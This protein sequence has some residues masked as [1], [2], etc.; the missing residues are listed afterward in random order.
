LCSN[1]G[2]TLH[3]QFVQVGSGS[4]TTL[5]PGVD[6]A[7]RNSYPSG[8]PNVIKN[9]AGKPIPTNDWWSAKLNKNHVSNLFTYPFTLKTVTSGLVVSYIP[10]GVIDDLEP[11]T[12]GVTGLNANKANVSDYSD[13]TVTL[14]WQN[15]SHE[16][17][18]TAGI[19]MP[20]LYFT[21]AAGD[22]AQVVV[23]SGSV[24]LHN[25][26]LVIQNAKNGASFAVYAPVG[27]TWTNNAGTY[28]SNL[29][30][31][32][33]WSM[34]FI[35]LTATNVTNVA[36]EYKKY[37]YVFPANT[38]VQWNYDESSSVVRTDFLVS[39]EVKEGSNDKMLIGLLPHQW[40]NLSSDS[41][42]PD[43]YS[44]ESVRG[45]IKTMEG[46]SFSVENT[47]KGILPTLPYLSNYSEGFNPAFLME[48][49][50]SIESESLS[51]W[52]DSYNEGQSMNRLIQVA[53]IADLMGNTVAL[54]KIK[55][56]IK[57]RLEDWLKAEAGEVAFLFYYNSTWTALI[58]YPAGHGQ[59]NNLNDHHFHWGYFIH[60]AAF[61]EQYEP[62]W[63]SQWGEMVN[64]LVRD[65]ASS[66]RADNMY[67]FLRNFS[68]YAGHCWAN[69]FATF[70][71]GNDQESTSESMQYNSSLIHWGQIT[72]NKDIR[73]LGIYLYT[74]EQTAIEEYWFDMYERNFKPN[75]QYSLVS[76]VWGNSYDNGTFWTSDIAA[77]YG[78]ELY[79]IHGGSTYLGH[80]IQYATKLW[81]EIK[82]NTGIMSNQVNVN[83][84]HDVMWQ[85]CSFT[86]P[87]TAIAL[88]NSFPN[89]QLKFG[90]ADAQT[91][92]WLHSMNALG[93]ID[94]SITADNPIALVFNKDGSKTYTAHNYSD[95]EIDVTFSDSYVLKV[96]ARTTAT[97][98]DIDISGV[99]STDFNRAYINGS[100][101]LKLNI[102][103]G[104]PSK[105]EFYRNEELLS[106]LT[107]A[108]FNFT[109][110]NLGV[111][112][113]HFF[114]KLYDGDNFNVSN[115]VSVIVGNQLPYNGVPFQV[116]GTIEAGLYDK[117]EGGNGQGITYQDATTFNEGGFRPEEYVDATIHTSEGATV[118][119]INAGEWLEYTVEVE[120]AGL[121]SLSFRYASGVTS[122][123]GPFHL[124]LDG[125]R[126]S[127]DI[128]VALTNTNWNVWA[129]KTIN[130]VRLK[131][132]KNILRIVFSAGGFN[133]GKMT[134]IRTGDLPYSQPIANAGGNKIVVLPNTSAILDGSNSNDPDSNP[135]SYKW[136]QVY[137]PSII[138]FSDDEIAKP[139]ISSLIEGVYLVKLTVNNGTYYDTDQI[140]VIVSASASIP[141]TVSIISPANNSVFTA[142]K[143]INITA[144]ADDIDGSVVKVDF[145]HNQ[146]LIGTSSSSP[147][148]VDWTPGVGDYEIYAVAT[149]NEE[150]ETTSEII[151]IRIDQ[152][153]ICTE[154][155]NIASQGSFDTGYKVTFETV[156]NNVTITFELLDNK[157]GVVAY[158]WKESPFSETQMTQLSDKIFSSTLTGQVQNSTISYACKFAFSGGMAVTKYFQYK[159]GTNCDITNVELSHNSKVAIFPNP[160]IDELYIYLPSGNSS[161][162]FYDIGGKMLKQLEVNEE[163]VRI[164]ISSFKSG[165]YFVK[166]FNAANSETFRLIKH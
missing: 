12:V 45:Q 156:G 113:H 101:S 135:I 22:V 165:I 104:V 27:S 114:A 155:S 142:G 56:T 19:A 59:D 162:Y 143:Q 106:T 127:D 146:T 115:F 4:Y 111:G 105:V 107:Q 90:V 124:E 74:T 42:V 31:A 50:Q 9:A 119:W 71:Q 62:G 20:F 51:D 132:G 78:I 87:E 2:L 37:A 91:Y 32:N 100:V 47:F 63:A 102:E 58:G 88:Y 26:M 139:E 141:P 61:L 130:N 41:P 49:I 154:T 164:N 112:K 5:F 17:E 138:I 140:Y 153:K 126:V 122:G 103:T 55:G 60:A 33:Y 125:E 15:S 108:P 68:P 80:N 75:Q 89:R 18:V 148:I 76:R 73:D 52:T 38:S 43:K 36:N 82:Q 96:P 131:Q 151:K 95:I 34:A 79:P 57:E 136:I 99:L 118:G 129:T 159:V 85:Y 3:A 72:G 23:K 48:K 134:F 44:Y 77:S 152:A 30:G 54:N 166:V 70:P 83:L 65:A 149:D 120:N 84:W 21:K 7:N 66:N 110:T 92:Y 94:A 157:T 161:I 93:I 16:F 10:W 29:N 46:N 14:N 150:N 163:L 98:K 28:T 109:A 40:S 145:Y 147:Y 123:G 39:S 13:W 35:P 158:L 1:F 81:N 6:A 121:H 11:V 97:S 116:P 64:H 8:T 137:G 53:R 67:P 117:F 86:D 128:T 133:L 144:I 25:E 160:A 24:T 69:G